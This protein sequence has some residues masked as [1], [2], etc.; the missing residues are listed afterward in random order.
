LRPIAGALQWNVM[1]RGSYWKI[2]QYTKLSGHGASRSAVWTLAAN[3]S[4]DFQ[5]LTEHHVPNYRVPNRQN[6]CVT[7][8]LFT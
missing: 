5:G 8:N 6:G 7:R 3:T 2:G 4:T 1:G